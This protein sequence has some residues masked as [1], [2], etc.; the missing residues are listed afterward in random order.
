MNNIKA[1]II[2]LT[3]FSLAL[4]FLGIKVYNQGK[5]AIEQYNYNIEY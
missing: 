1:L 4:A 2:L 3:F 5:E